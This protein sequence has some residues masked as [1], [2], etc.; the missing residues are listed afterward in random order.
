MF[1]RI[2][3]TMAAPNAQASIDAFNDAVAAENAA[4]AA[5]GTIPPNVHETIMKTLSPP[6]KKQPNVAPGAPGKARAGISKTRL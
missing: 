2:A 1:E 5:G 4:K 6:R 3:I